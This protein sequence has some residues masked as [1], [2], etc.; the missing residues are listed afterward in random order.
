MTP[1]I[2]TLPVDIVDVRVKGL[3]RRHLELICNVKNPSDT[4]LVILDA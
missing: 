3:P 4:D 1:A 2:P